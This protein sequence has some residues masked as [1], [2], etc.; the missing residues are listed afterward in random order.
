M[1]K[2]ITIEQCSDNSYYIQFNDT[3]C[4]VSWCINKNGWY[5]NYMDVS[6]N[7]GDAPLPDWTTAIQYLLECD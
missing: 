2:I 1:N 5:L 6:L 3:Q 4:S 7:L